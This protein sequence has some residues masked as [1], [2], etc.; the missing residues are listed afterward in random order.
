MKQLKK[1]SSVITVK[2]DTKIKNEVS[3]VLEQ[4]GTNTSNVIN[5]LL[6]QIAIQK[7][8]P[9]EIT[10]KKKKELLKRL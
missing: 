1:E 9:F 7:E 3:K 8:I 10:L 2:V 5:M 4:L 6:H